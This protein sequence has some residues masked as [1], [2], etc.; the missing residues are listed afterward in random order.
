MLKKAGHKSQVVQSGDDFTRA[1]AAEQ[2]HVVIADYSDAA[3]LNALLQAVPSQAWN[4]PLPEQAE[5]RR[6]SMK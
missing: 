2:D 3:K 1:V 4:A 6:W 5:R